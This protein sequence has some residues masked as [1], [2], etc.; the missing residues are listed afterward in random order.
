MGF[1]TLAIII[2]LAQLTGSESISSQDGVS[3]R[4]PTRDLSNKLDS[5]MGWKDGYKEASCIRAFIHGIYHTGVGAYKYA[6]GSSD[7]A[8]AEYNRATNQFSKCRKD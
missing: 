5:V 3:N 4:K 8:Y 7:N 1:L 2:L 6:R